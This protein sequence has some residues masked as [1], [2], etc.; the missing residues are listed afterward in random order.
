MYFCFKMGVLEDLE[1]GAGC[2]SQ[3]QEVKDGNVVGH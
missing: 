3:I 1:G 2:M